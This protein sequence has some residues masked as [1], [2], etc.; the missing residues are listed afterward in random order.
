VVLLC[1]VLV[2]TL[3]T[4]DTRSGLICFVLFRGV[5]FSPA[6]KR[7]NLAWHQPLIAIHRGTIDVIL[8]S[9]EKIIMVNYWGLPLLV[10]NHLVDWNLVYYRPKGAAP[11]HVTA[12]QPVH[13]LKR[14]SFS[15]TF[16]D[17]LWKEIFPWHSMICEKNCFMSFIC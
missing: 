9:R 1:S 10:D 8:V 17:V 15:T 11:T 16:Y 7:T 6:V 2:F 12:W 13:V 3:K 4:T 5:M 14:E